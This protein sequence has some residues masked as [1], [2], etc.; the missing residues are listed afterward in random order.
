MKQKQTITSCFINPC[1]YCFLISFHF[2]LIDIRLVELAV[3]RRDEVRKWEEELEAQRLADELAAKNAAFKAKSLL[4]RSDASEPIVKS[5]ANTKANAKSLVSAKSAS[6]KFVSGKSIVKLPSI[7]GITTKDNNLSTLDVAGK[8]G[9]TATAPAVDSRLRA[10]S[11]NPKKKRLKVV[12][13][14]RL[15]R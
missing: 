1:S 5:L 15:S 9:A 11:P 6:G 4:D 3:E 12:Y 10:G 7:E 14:D 2:N 13:F 8:A